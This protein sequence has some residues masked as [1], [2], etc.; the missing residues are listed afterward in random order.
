MEEDGGEERGGVRGHGEGGYMRMIDVLEAG[1][2]AS[3]DRALT[4]LGLPRPSCSLIKH[5]TRPKQ[6]TPRARPP[7]SGLAHSLTFLYSQLP[8]RGAQVKTGTFPTSKPLCAPPT[9]P[10]LLDAVLVLPRPPEA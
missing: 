10:R 1:E 6:N 5:T 9:S 8:P 3:T 7:S 2:A 4:L